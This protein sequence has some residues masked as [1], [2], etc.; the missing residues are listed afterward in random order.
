MT[1]SKYLGQGF[2]KNGS[3]KP[4]SDTWMMLTVEHLRNKQSLKADFLRSPRDW[5]LMG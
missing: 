5:Y 3:S 4:S 2:F 1:T